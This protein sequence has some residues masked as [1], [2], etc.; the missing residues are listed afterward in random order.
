MLGCFRIN[1]SLFDFKLC[2]IF[3]KC[4]DVIISYFARFS[5]FFVSFFNNLIINISKIHNKFYIVTFVLKISSHNI[6]HNERARITDMKVIVNSWSAH[7]NF[8]FI[9]INWNKFFY[10]FVSVL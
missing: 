8:N 5:I 2:D 3:K 4:I 7:I 9:W 10:F 1:I 6:R